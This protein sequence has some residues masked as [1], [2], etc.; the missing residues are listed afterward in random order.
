MLTTISLA[1]MIIGHSAHTQTGAWLKIISQTGVAVRYYAPSR[2]DSSVMLFNTRTRENAFSVM[3]EFSDNRITVTLTFK[4]HDS[5]VEMFGEATHTGDEDVC[6]TVKII[7]PSGGLRN[8][9][10]SHD[11]DSAVAPGPA[12]TIMSN[13]VDASTV[14]PPGGAFNTDDT[15][16]GGYGDKLGAGQMSFYPLAAIASDDIG[17]AWGVDMSIPLVF[18]LAFD[19]GTG[20]IAEF[21]LATSRETKQ[22]PQRA[23]FKLF[24]FEYDPGW[25]MRAALEKFYTIQPEYFK[26]RVTQ[27]G[28]WLPFAPLWEIDNWQDFGFAFHET[29]MHSIDRGLNPAISTIEAGKKANVLTFQYTEPWEEEI[30]I[31]KLDLTYAQVTGKETVPEEHAQYL[32]TSAALDKENKWITRKLET[33]W[34]PSGWALSINTNTDPDIDGFNRYDYVCQR[35]IYPALEMNVDGIYFDCLEWHWQYDLNY[36]RSHFA[37]TDYPL[38]FSSSL[39]SPRP[40]VWSYASE[41]E[42]V[43][44]VADDMHRQGKYVMGNTLYWL[45]FAAG[46]LDVFGSELSWYIPDDTKMARLQFARAIAHQK[47]VVF[48]LNEG[49]DDT[50]FTRPPFGGYSAYFDRML[51]YGFFPSFFSVN[52]T[53]NIY[54]ADSARYNQGRPFFKKYIPIIK[55]LTHAGWQPVTFARLNTQGVRIERFGNVGSKD[56]YFTLYNPHAAA[57]RTVITIDA[58]GLNLDNVMSMEELMDG[59]Q[60]DARRHGDAL[61]VSLDVKGT[62]ARVIKI[63][64]Q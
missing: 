33:P 46:V 53:S 51:L 34:F 29:N 50:V 40:V 14:I 63:A 4:K 38:T 59:R 64:R 17:L 58:A 2:S 44:R 57:V 42:F 7:A 20:M 26:K 48:L 62:T 55:A 37:R 39:R 56:V 6:L 24:F 3:K 43:H 25:G 54:W 23:F 61:T 47:P 28:I 10:W 45:P 9:A 1:L 27:E 21:D 60:L 49:L 11:L 8:V 12:G 16:N 18:R 30:P 52:A 36:N 15:H 19:R 41:Y 35:E 22:F 32:H 13:Y 31:H 5:Y